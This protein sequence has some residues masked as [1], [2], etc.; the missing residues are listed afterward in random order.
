MTPR[1]IRIDR[2]LTLLVAL[3]LIALGLL[4]I[5][6]HQQRVLQTY[7]SELSTGPARGVVVTAWFPWAFAAAGVVL[8]LIGL[9]LLV[10][11]LGRRGPSTLRLNASDETG[12]IQADLRSIADAAAARLTKLT[13]LTDVTGTILDSGSRTVILLRARI[14]PVASVGSITDAARVCTQDVARAFPDQAIACRILID[15]PRRGRVRRQSHV[16]VR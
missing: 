3:A 14:D 8:G 12:H 7:P 2:A 13:S 10:A 1:T 4:L 6:W 15:P 5:D 9:M 11:H 16:R